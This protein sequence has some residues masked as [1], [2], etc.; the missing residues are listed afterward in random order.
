VSLDL[1]RTR[2]LTD[3][4]QKS[5]QAD[6]FYVDERQGKKRKGKK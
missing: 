1:E 5:F 6:F 4:E 2:P 3:A